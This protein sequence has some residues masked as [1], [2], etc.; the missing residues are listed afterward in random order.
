MRCCAASSTTSRS[1]ISIIPALAPLPAPTGQPS[2][3]RPHSAAS[4][5]PPLAGAPEQVGTRRCSALSTGGPTIAGGAFLLA[6]LERN[7][8]RCLPGRF[9]SA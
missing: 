9:S 2:R 3:G 6:C 4:L 1:R 7:R 5:Q 8:N